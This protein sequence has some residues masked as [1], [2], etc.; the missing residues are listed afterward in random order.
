MRRHQNSLN[1]NNGFQLAGGMGRAKM[2]PRRLV[3]R[4]Q[5]LAVI[6]GMVSCLWLADSRADENGKAD[7]VLQ[8]G[9][10]YT[11]DRARSFQQSIA[12]TGN[13]IVAIGH[14]NKVKLLVGPKTKVV[15]LGGKLVLPGMIDTHSHP[16][17]SV[18]ERTKCSLADIEVEPPT[19]EALK[20]VIR[21]CLRKK[22]GGPNHWLE[23]VQLYNYGFKATAYDLDKIEKKRP[24]ALYGNDGHT[25]WVNRRGLALLGITRD[26]PDPHDGK[27]HRDASGTPTGLLLEGAMDLVGDISSPPTIEEQASL[28]AAALNNMSANGITSLMDACVEPTGEAVWR[29]L[30][31]TGKLDMRVRMAIC[32]DPNEDSDE[33]VAQLVE[34]SKKDNVDP[35]FLRAGVVK[36]YA[37]GVLEY[38]S[39][40]AALLAPYLH[41]PTKTCGALYID[42]SFAKLVTKLDAAGLAVHVHAIGDKAVRKTLDAFAAARR[43]NGDRDN[44]HQIA[45]LELVNPADFPRFKA[46]GVIADFQL[47]WARREPATVEAVKPYLGP[48]RYRYLYPAGS[49][50]KAGA[51]IVGGSDWAVSSYNPFCAF[52]NAVTRGGG[53]GQKPLNIDQKI[54][55]TA[56]VDAYTINAAFAMKQDTT[57]GSLE[58]GK[59]ADLVILDR[60]IFTVDANTIA[61]TEVLATYLDG[62]LVYTAPASG[63][64]RMQRCDEIY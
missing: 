40:T 47:L 61:D 58:V 17:D 18:V 10:I 20:P 45:H 22:P 19:I 50:L 15:D 11:A 38:P 12:F 35:N 6:V 9:K 5:V 25:V 26:T 3:L 27:I 52:Q 24:I 2:T 54:P 34:T 21:E 42:D 7:V 33:M 32:H 44:R 39:Q 46:L 36:V 14:D 30:Y 60:D 23:V 41:T 28:T 59:R 13:S 31:R 64:S 56:A 1:F 8:H 29:Q 63:T 16:I 49:L 4:I 57:T 55:L 48:K 53:K 62:R 37:D 43:A 51:T